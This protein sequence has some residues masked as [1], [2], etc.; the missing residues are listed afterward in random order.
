[1]TKSKIVEFINKNI[2]YINIE[3]SEVAGT[4][5][6]VWIDNGGGSDNDFTEIGVETLVDLVQKAYLRGWADGNVEK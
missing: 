2:D 5:P 1:M 4:S 3:I 6:R